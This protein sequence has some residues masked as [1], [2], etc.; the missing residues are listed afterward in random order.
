MKLESRD[1]RWSPIKALAQIDVLIDELGVP[2][3]NFDLES[4][5]ILEFSDLMNSDNSEI[6]KFLVLYGGY[7]AYLESQLAD[8]DAKR[9]AL[10]AAFDEG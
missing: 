7:K 10:E 1:T 5:P 3:F 8:C 2:K 4:V 6:E 9:S